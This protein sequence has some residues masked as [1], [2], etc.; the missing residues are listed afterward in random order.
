MEMLGQLLKLFSGVL[1]G[2]EAGRVPTNDE[3]AR[4]RQHAETWREQLAGLQQRLA[5]ATIEPPR[6]AQ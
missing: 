4:F 5:S 2:A 6:R 1:E 3:I